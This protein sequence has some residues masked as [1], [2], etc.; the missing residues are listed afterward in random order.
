M[1]CARTAS[2]IAALFVMIRWSA[3]IQMIVIFTVGAVTDTS[4]CAWSIPVAGSI[5][6][7]GGAMSANKG[8]TFGELGR[9]DYCPLRQPQYASCLSC[10]VLSAISQL[11]PDKTAGEKMDH[12]PPPAVIDNDSRLPRRANAVEWSANDNHAGPGSAANE[13]EEL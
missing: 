13:S 11:V 2:V 7:W 1:A 5:V 3:A 9:F 8:L 12:L 4:C 6:W 10:R